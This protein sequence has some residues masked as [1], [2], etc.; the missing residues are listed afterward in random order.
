MQ[1]LTS[2]L[3][4][5]GTTIIC[6][7][8]ASYDWWNELCRY[9][10]KSGFSKENIN[11]YF[12]AADSAHKLLMN[13]NLK[14]IIVDADL[15]ILSDVLKET[16]KDNKD[17]LRTKAILTPYDCADNTDF[18]RLM[19]EYICVRSFAVNTMRHGAPM[20]LEL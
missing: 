19:E 11:C 12:L 13:N 6:R 16:F 15:D 3:G 17:D 5:C 18:K 20:E 1:I 2:V 10:I 9:L 7:S 8:Q 4:G 14:T